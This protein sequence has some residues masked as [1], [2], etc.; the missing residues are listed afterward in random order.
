MGYDNWKVTERDPNQFD[1]REDTD[2]CDLCGADDGDP[3]AADCANNQK[4]ETPAIYAEA[5]E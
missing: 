1:D 4:T 5:D 2:Y 3:C